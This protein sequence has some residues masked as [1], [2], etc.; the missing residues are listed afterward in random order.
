MTGKRRTG[1]ALSRSEAVEL[2][3]KHWRRILRQQRASKLNHT[4]FCKKKSISRNAYFWWKREILLRDA[5]RRSQKRVHQ[6]R[7]RKES[8]GQALVPVRIRTQMDSAWAFEV[9][10]SNNRLVRV[11]R[12]FDPEELRRLVAAL[13]ESDAC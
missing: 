3:E 9:V 13:E 1:H 4:D 10:L 2:R 8:L 12:D 6:R 7:Q 11:P 5:K